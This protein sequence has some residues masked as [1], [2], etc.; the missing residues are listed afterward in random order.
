MGK[1]PGIRLGLGMYGSDIA[2]KLGRRTRSVVKQARYKALFDTELSKDSSAGDQFVLTNGSEYMADSL[3]GQF[4]GNRFDG[5]IVDDPIKGRLEANSETIRNNTW[6]EFR[7]NFLTRL[8]PKGWLI[9]AMTNW[10]EDAPAGRILP[11]GWSGESGTFKGKFD[12]LDWEVL[13][14]QAKCENLTDPLGRKIGEYLAPEWFDP[15]HWSQFENEPISWNALYQQRPRP[16][17]GA[18]FQLASFLVDGKPIDW[19]YPVGLG[20]IYLVFAI[21]DTA[22]KSGKSHDGTAVT[23]FGYDPHRATP[24]RLYILDWDIRHIDGASLETWLPS[25]FQRGQELANECGALMGFR[26]TWIE[27]KGSGIVLIQQATNKGWPVAPIDTKLSA[28]GKNERAFNASSY[29]SAGEVKI[30][31]HAFEK[32]V[33]FKGSRKNHWLSQVLGFAMDSGDTAADDL[34]DTTTYGIAISIG[35][36]EGF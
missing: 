14:L 35:N 22:M 30:T 7:D 26:G 10:H 33:E 4:P 15:T 11:D 13:C 25:V 29:V 34:L 2:G 16:P 8:V 1:Y 21:I 3:G 23:F 19:P 36:R 17:E 12:G 20:R 28:M 6:D 32:V 24:H 9:M 5:A 31:R 27:D 18:Y